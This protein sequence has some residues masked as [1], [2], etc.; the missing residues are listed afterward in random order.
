MVF[1]LSKWINVVATKWS[2]L[3]FEQFDKV[4]LCDIDTLAVADYTKIFDIKTM[5]SL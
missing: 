1:S 5:S 4:L 3:Y 2:I